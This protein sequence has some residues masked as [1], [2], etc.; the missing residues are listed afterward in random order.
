V[1]KGELP[2]LV[3]A[4]R[5]TDILSALKLAKDFNLKLVLDGAAESYLLIDQIKAAGV[6]V[7][8]HPRCSAATARP[9]NLSMETAS[10]LRAAGIPIALQSAYEGYVPKTRVVLFE[11]A[12]AAANGLSF[13]RRPR[14]DHARCGKRSWGSTSAS[15]RSRRA[16]TPTW[17][18]STATRLSTPA[19]APPRSSTVRS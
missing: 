3:T 11:A 18:V 5:A 4:H 6:P 16:R 7:I 1:L 15:A 17:P 10:K 14:L 9:K 2:V 8:I 12:L 19:T 13:R